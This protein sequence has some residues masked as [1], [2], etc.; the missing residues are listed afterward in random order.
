MSRGVEIDNGSTRFGFSGF[1]IRGVGGNRTA[2]LIDGVPVPDR[3]AVGNFSDSGRGLI[4]L[5]LAGRI[6]ILRGPASTL[7]GSK[8]LGGRSSRST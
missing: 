4:N 5:G 8:A 6:E 3:F 1:R 7:Y 2:V